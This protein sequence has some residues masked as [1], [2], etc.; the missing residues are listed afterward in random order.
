MVDAAKKQ[1]ERPLHNDKSRAASELPERGAAEGTAAGYSSQ[2]HQTA[3]FSDQ[4]LAAEQLVIVAAG[5][6]P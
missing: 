2:L 6:C 1:G 4:G 3:D 5:Q